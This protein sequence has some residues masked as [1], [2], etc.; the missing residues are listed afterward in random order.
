MPP[1]DIRILLNP[2][3]TPDQLFAFYEKNDICEKGFGKEVAARVLDHSDV[4]VGA[5][6]GDELVGYGRALF[7]GLSGDIVDLCVDLECQ[8]GESKLRN[9]SLIEHDEQG[10]AKALMEAMIRELFAMGATFISTQCWPEIEDVEHL[11]ELGF[12]VNEGSVEYIIDRRPYVMGE[13]DA[14]D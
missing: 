10:V 3:I 1:A 5:F 7:D 14:A 12:T 9:G 8:G 4:I 6:R 11:R 2:T 13:T